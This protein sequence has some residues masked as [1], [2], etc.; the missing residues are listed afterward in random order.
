M[1]ISTN[2]FDSQLNDLINAALEDLR[3][4]GVEC[5]GESTSIPF[6][7]TTTNPLV[8]LAVTTYCKIHFNEAK[9]ERLIDV[10]FS[11]SSNILLKLATYWVLKLDKSKLSKAVELNMLEKVI[12]FEVSKSLKSTFFNFGHSQNI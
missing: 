6:Q 3:I 12:A 9:D 1:R 5:V 2:T 10:K 7:S 8:I 4:A 11:Q